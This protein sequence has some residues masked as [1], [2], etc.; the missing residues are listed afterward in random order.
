ME[1]EI[2]KKYTP[3][4]LYL[5]TL[6]VRRKNDEEDVDVCDDVIGGGFGGL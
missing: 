2:E 5:Y 6:S 3:L 1:I 4:Y